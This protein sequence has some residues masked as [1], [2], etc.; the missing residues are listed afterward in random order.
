[1]E[2]LDL[3]GHYKLNDAEKKPLSFI[4]A[5][6]ADQRLLLSS[7]PGDGEANKGFRTKPSTRA[8]S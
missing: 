5:Q 6:G 1:M 8:G 4:N 7:Y 2:D 3:P